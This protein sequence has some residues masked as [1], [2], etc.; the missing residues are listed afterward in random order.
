MTCNDECGP[1][2]VGWSP[3]S[4]VLPL[5]KTEVWAP[6][7]GFCRHVVVEGFQMRGRYKASMGWIA[8]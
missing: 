4:L 6:S 7:C 8:D 1:F 2:F 3:Y 5:A